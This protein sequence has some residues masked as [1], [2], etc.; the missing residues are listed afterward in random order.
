ME[1]GSS[2]A[3]HLWRGLSD[4]PVS[5]T[6]CVV[7]VLECSKDQIGALSNISVSRGQN[8]KLALFVTIARRGQVFT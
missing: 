2:S 6:E 7:Q 8:V 3:P 5:L 1:C 4:L